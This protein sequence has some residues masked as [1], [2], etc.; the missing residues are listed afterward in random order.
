MNP[1]RVVGFDAFVA[2]LQGINLPNWRGSCLIIRYLGNTMDSSGIVFC[3]HRFP[4]TCFT[5]FLYS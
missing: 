5:I 3:F 1:V 4:K 2:S